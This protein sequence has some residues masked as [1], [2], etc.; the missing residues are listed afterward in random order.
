MEEAQRGV[1]SVE[2]AKIRLDSGEGKL[3]QRIHLQVH[4]M[5][6][7]TNYISGINRK[8]DVCGTICNYLSS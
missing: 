4:R 3:I 1:K 5:T 2:F 7:A 6:Y 8:N